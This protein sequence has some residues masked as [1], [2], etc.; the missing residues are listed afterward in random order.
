M[1]V[2]PHQA[3]F[4]RGELSPAL[5]GR[6]DI[7]HFR[8]GLQECINWA[9]MRQGGLDR[10]TGTIFAGRVKFHDKKTGV[11]AFEFS[12]D[13]AYTLEWGDLY[14]RFWTNG[15]RVE[16]AGQTITGATQADPCVITIVGHGYVNG[17]S[18]YIAGVGGMVELNGEEYIVANKTNDAFELTGVDS[19]GFT[20]FTSGGTASLITEVATPY[21]EDDLVKIQVEQSGDVIYIGCEGYAPRKLIRAGETSW[22]IEVVDFK[23]GPYLAE[24]ETATTLTPAN[25][26]GLTPK[27]TNNTSPSGTANAASDSADAWKAFDRDPEVNYSTAGNALGW[28]SFAAGSSKVADRYWLQVSKT[29]SEADRTPTAWEFQGY[30]G[31]VWI[32][33]DK[34]AGEEGWA[35]SETRY[36]EFVNVVVYSS[37]RLKWTSVDGGTTSTIAELGINIAGDDQTAFNLTASTATGINDD[38]GFLTTDVGRSIRLMGS[39]SLWR[40][41]RIVS[42]TSSTVVTIRLYGHAL[43][44]LNPIQR[45]KMSAFYVDNYP[46]CVAFFEER[47][48]WA[49]TPLSP[50]TVWLSKTLAYEDMGD[51]QPVVGD[52]ALELAMTGGKLNMVAWME[53][54]ADLKIGTSGSAR[55]IGANDLSSG[56]S[57]TNVKQRRHTTVGASLIRP[58]TIEDTTIF[59]DRRKTRL[60]EFAFDYER[61]GYATP[62][63]TILSDHL[64]LSGALNIAYQQN[65][66]NLIWVPVVNGRVVTV[67]YHKEQQ[68]VGCA[69]QEFGGTGVFVESACT[70][71]TTTDGDQTWFVVKRTIDGETRRYIEYGSPPFT[72]DSDLEDACFADSALM[73]DGASTTTLSGLDHLEGETVGV[74]GDGIDLGDATVAGGAITLPGGASASKATVGLR[75]LSTG[76]TLRLPQAGN[77]DGGHLGRL[78]RINEVI[79]DLLNTAG[80]EAGTPTRTEDVALRSLDDDLETPQT[81]KTG[82]FR[83]FAEDS[84]R[85]GGVVVFKTDSMYPATVRGLLLGVEGEP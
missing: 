80:L 8:M 49:A 50:R 1:T 40:W 41:A 7:D 33:L 22:S 12:E 10:R 54:G 47:L 23:D 84:W 35:A 75:Y 70:I 78:A 24:N 58:V 14:V 57:A 68:I 38:A 39:D 28:I 53:E 11:L 72:S 30:N 4:V 59:V 74:L 48:G 18:V 31:S 13:Q 73:Y 44:D 52:D 16:E 83:V 20:A 3:T 77:Q 45:W 32:T 60:H 76:K 15:G 17:D 85:N 42:R 51:S 46:R 43:P 36:Y 5:H 2:Y 81:L 9:V 65:P 66:G 79:I 82:T 26:G 67:T 56:F 71:P 64:F 19:S 62:E 61:G 6:V 25:T 37:Y 55:T 63:L 34:R 21:V 29:A 27:M 69:P